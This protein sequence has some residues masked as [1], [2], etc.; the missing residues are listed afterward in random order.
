MREY[1]P[2][3]IGRKFEERVKQALLK[4]HYLLIDKNLFV[5]NYA[6]EKDYAKKRE[7]DLVMFNTHEKEFYVVECKAHISRSNLVVYEQVRKFNAVALN[8]GGR[9]AKK[10]IVTDT[11]LSRQ[12]YEY[13][14]NK[15]IAVI[16]GKKLEQMENEPQSPHL[17]FLAKV[18]KLGLESIVKG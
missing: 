3:R 13:A 8:Y 18:L 7:Y 12:A 9:W 11:E 1:N 5:K 4:N 16:N 17:P 10:L 2:A 14:R 15:N 6:P